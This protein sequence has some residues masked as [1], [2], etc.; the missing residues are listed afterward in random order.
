MSLLLKKLK[1]VFLACYS[2]AQYSILWSI[3]NRKN[4]W[5]TL[6]KSLKSFIDLHPV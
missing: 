1:I 3:L 5:I 4:V 2:E 6:Q